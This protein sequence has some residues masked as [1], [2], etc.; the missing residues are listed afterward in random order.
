MQMKKS[1][2][3]LI[4][5]LA[6]IF[7]GTFLYDAV[8]VI[9]IKQY[10][11]HYQ[12]PA[13]SVSIAKVEAQTWH[14]SFSA[15]GTLKAANG[16]EINAQVNG[17]ITAI[18]FESGQRVEKGAPL[19]QLDDAIDR[20]TLANNLAQL[21]ADK[22]D[23]DRKLQLSKSN[24]VAQSEVDVAKARWLESQAAVETAKLN[25]A[26]KQI[27]APFS[28]KIGI[29]QI[30]I[31][32]FIMAGK[33]LVSLQALNPLY[34]DFSLPEQDLASLQLGLPVEVKVDT[35][36][37]ALFTGKI[38]AL[39]SQVDESTRTLLVRAII[40]NEKEHLYPGLYAQVRVK[41]PQKNQVLTIPQT[42]VNYSLYGNTVFV[43][44]Q[45]GK[46]KKGKP[47]FVATER[48]VKLGSRQGDDIA[49]LEGLNLGETIVIAGQ[50]KLQPGAQITWNS[51]G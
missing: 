25:I 19:I 44:E 24:G 17:Q 4:I 48:F 5:I 23:Y 36:P 46:D 28:G 7:G 41:L 38:S 35:Y 47:I 15:V 6:V 45:K 33:D 14:P 42:A 1:W 37:K 16:V 34:V 12:V 2:I 30:N 21:Q 49:V 27:V 26:Y 29:R 31:G 13:V 22:L 10:F 9:M 50:V 11:A 43:V 39:N 8:R 40:M 18:Y 32:Q 20:Q 51:N 3:I